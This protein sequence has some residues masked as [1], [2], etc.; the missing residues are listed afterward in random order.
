MDAGS[1]SARTG[2]RPNARETFLLY[3]EFGGIGNV[4]EV[5]APVKG[6]NLLLLCKRTEVDVPT[7]EMTPKGRISSYANWSASFD[8][9]TYTNFI[10]RSSSA[11]H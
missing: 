10:R 8:P 1:M 3:K 11:H 6:V 7:D 2:Q 9:T 4:L 5:C